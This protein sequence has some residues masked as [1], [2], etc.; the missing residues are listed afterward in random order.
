MNVQNLDPTDMKKSYPLIGLI[1]SFVFAGCNNS[2]E[3]TIHD[4]IY[5]STQEAAELLNAKLDSTNTI[6]ES[7]ASSPQQNSNNSE[8]GHSLHY[9][10][11]SESRLSAQ[12]AD[13]WRSFTMSGTAY[14][15]GESFPIKIKGQVK[16]EGGRLSF[17]GCKYTN[18]TQKVTFD[19]TVKENGGHLSVTRPVKSETLDIEASR[20][21][22]NTWDG[23]MYTRSHAFPITL[24]M[25]R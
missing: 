24:T 4:T 21:G 8:G 25:S 16:D 17:K 5:V 7:D 11:P 6:S 3:K 22:K 15:E 23:T 14:W 20:S 18:I 12:P 10:R 1:L 13:S 9:S 2:K 19:V